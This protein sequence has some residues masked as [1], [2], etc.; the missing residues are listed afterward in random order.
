MDKITVNFT[1]ET[2]T[3][4]PMHAVGQPPFMGIDF[5]M[6][7]YLQKAHI[8]YSRLHDVGGAFGRNLF[9]DIPNIFRDFSADADDPESYDFAFTDLLISALTERGIEPFFRL[10][11][12]IEN[13]SKIKAYR[14][15]PPKD[16]HKWAVIC[17]HIIRHY[18]EGWANGFF[19]KITY[20]E[21]WNEPDNYEDPKENQ[22]WTGTPEEYYRLYEVASKHLKEKFPHLKIGGYA[23]CGFYALT[24][25][26]N[27]F[28]ACTPRYQ[29]FMD[30][31]DGFLD[32]IQRHH[33][34]LDFFSW[35]SY[36]EIEVNVLWAEYVRKRLDEAGYSHTEHTLNEW[37]C[38][39][40]LKGTAKH[41][42]LTCGMMLA[43]QNTTLDSAMF[44]DAR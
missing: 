20:W 5:S 39:P 27:Q 37:N 21:I 41:A 13:Y 14:I 26:S 19:H 3:I 8:P 33:C 24:E 10:G 42:A 6:C 9:V 12:T 35:H 17:E 34:P 28:G 25:S 15:H 38:C 16:H 18:T 44:Y 7:D 22:M 29:Y 36:S 30:F 31:F 4:K 1:Q 11:V 23:S 2:G 32:Y 40:D 43:L